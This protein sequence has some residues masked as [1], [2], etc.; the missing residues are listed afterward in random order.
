MP[1]QTMDI[2][3]FHAVQEPFEGQT[4]PKTGSGIQV[5]LES[6]LHRYTKD[7]N[8]AR[9]VGVPL[10]PAGRALGWPGLQ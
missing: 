5:V 1:E 3:R 10:I 4:E 7:K 9:Y 6:S 8:E 2:G